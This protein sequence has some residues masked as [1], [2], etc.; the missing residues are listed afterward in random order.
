MKKKYVTRIFAVSMALITAAATGASPVQAGRLILDAKA[1]VEGSRSD[2]LRL[3]YD[4]PASL[5]QTILSGGAFDT[6]AED[7]QWQ[8]FTLPIGNSFMGANVYGEISR[9]HLTFNHKTL[10]NGG[11]SESRPYYNG[12]NITDQNGKPTSEIFKQVQD[13]FLSGQAL[14]AQQLCGWLTGA[15]PDAGYGAYQSWGDIYIDFGLAEH[16]ITNYV[17]DLDLTTAVANVDFNQESTSYHREYFI[18]Y[19]DNVLAIKLKADGTQKLNFDISFP[20]DNATSQKLGK[21]ATIKALGD[22]LTTAGVMNDNQMKFNSI[23]RVIPANGSVKE[24][25]TDKLTISNANSVTIFVSAGTD[26]K[27]SYPDYRTGETDE[28]LKQR[29]EK[30]V[31]AAVLKGYDQVKSD[32]IADYQNIYN[33]VSL[34]LLQ[35]P[36]QV[37]TDEQL[38]QYNN[39]TG[40]PAQNRELEVKLYQYGRYLTI[41]SSR[42]GD[43][44]SNLQGVWNNRVGDANR[45]PWGSDYHMNVNLQMNYWPVYSANMTEC[46]IPLIDY[47]NS[48]VEP[49]ELTAQTYFGTSPGNGW[50]AHTQNN[51]FGWTCPGWSFNWGW[52]PAAV[53]WILQNCWDYYEYTGDQEFMQS[54]LYPMMKEQALLYDHILRWDETTKRIIS[55][56]S[57]SPEHGPISMGNTYEQSLIWQL[58]TDTIKAANILGVDEGLV[59]GWEATRSKLNPISVGDSGQIKEWPEE[60]TL[61]SIGESGHRHMSHLLGLY[62]GDL[63][64]VDS[65]EYMEAAII[66]LKSRGDE[67]TGWGMGQR[68][69][70]WARTGDGNH[71]YQLIQTLFKNGIYPNL[72]DSHPPFQ[73]DGNFGMTAGVTE[74]LLQSNMGYLNLLPA[75]PDA[76]SAGSVS[77]L[78]A[79]GNFEVDMGWEDGGLTTASI[80]SNNGGTCVVKYPSL[81]KIQIEADNGTN[82]NVNV[83]A[84]DKISFETEQGTAYTFVNIPEA[85]LKAP[86][87]VEAYRFGLQTVQINAAQV[88]NAELYHIFRSVNSGAFEKIAET[89]TLPYVD[90]TIPDNNENY[91]YKIAAVRNQAEGKLS[92]A[93]T[94]TELRGLTKLD[95]RD[96]LIRYSGFLNW[97]PQD[98]QYMETEKYSVT[99]GSTAVLTFAGTGI[100]VIGMKNIDTGML[101]VYLDGQL[102]QTD[103]DTYSSS[104][105]RNQILYHIDNLQQGVH[106]LRLVVTGKKN[107]YSAGIKISL[108]AFDILD[109]PALDTGA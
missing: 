31:S 3:W 109:A 52:S 11:P 84:P 10:W 90:H 60:T 72:W 88:Q 50:T 20:V 105:R 13:L 77:G 28:E 9:E 42:E 101:D 94:V 102:V 51:P 75:L 48:L 61:G 67:S 70:T 93:V 64:S 53:P 63:I 58:Y 100:R 33:R 21:T 103:I 46:A 16:N 34:D 27:N 81:S 44:P 8:Q 43:L 89:A 65:P 66:S 23:L 18:S 69:N 2:N 62:P 41:A 85:P 36:S 106:T 98:G 95:D 74:M 96:R 40:S 39:H 45:I 5:G 91:K 7:N 79:Q 15:E 22:T 24:T 97:G 83:I 35:S 68:I 32:H 80:R 107:S 54:K 12:G 86:E 4:K 57:Y 78:M 26:Y 25:G 38:T 47:V 71:A 87:S 73:I 55:V 104:T 99:Q 1:A 76:W 6:T 19:P 82:V 29:V 37:P 56:P 14:Q 59:A 30:V 49:G 17:R 108:D 92:E